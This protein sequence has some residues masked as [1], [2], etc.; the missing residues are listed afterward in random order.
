MSVKV[1]PREGAVGSKWP[2]LWGLETLC[3]CLLQIRFG[4]FHSQWFLAHVSSC[5]SRQVGGWSRPGSQLS[6]PRHWHALQSAVS[7]P[8]TGDIQLFG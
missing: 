6:G 2:G 7:C 3:V 8:G 1:S 5:P 4:N